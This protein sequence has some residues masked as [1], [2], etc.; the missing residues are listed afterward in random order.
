METLG[1]V[2]AIVLGAGVVAGAAFF[3]WEIPSLVRY[4]R[5]RR[6]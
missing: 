3:V 2:T 4:L 6:M 5:I 1:Y